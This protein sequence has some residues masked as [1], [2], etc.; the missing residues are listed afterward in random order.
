MITA[1][2]I[3]VADYVTKYSDL[4]VW[5]SIRKNYG[6][7][8]Y[9]AF[10]CLAAHELDA[11][12]D[13]EQIVELIKKH[14]IEDGD[15]IDFV[16]GIADAPVF[17]AEILDIIR[18]YN[19]MDVIGIY[20]EYLAEDF[21]M[22]NQAV[23]F[24]C[25]KNNRDLL[26]S[27]YTR[28]DFAYQITKKA[29][30][31]YYL[32]NAS[33]TELLRVAD[34]SCGGGAFLLS[35]ARFCREKNIPICLYGYDVDPI[36]VLITRLRLAKEMGVEIAAHIQL[37]N[38]LL[39]E[40]KS[41]GGINLFKKAISGR[42]YHSDMGISVEQNID[43]VIGNPPWEKIRFEEKKFLHHYIADEEISTK[44]GREL[45]LHQTLKENQLYYDNMVSD[46]QQTKKKIKSNPLFSLTNCG[47]LNTYALFTELSFNLLSDHGVV[48]LIIKSSLVKMP[49]YRKFFK[50]ITQY[51]N[52]YELYMFVNR[53]KLFNID[54]R[55]EFSV[56][57][58]KKENKSNLKLA[59][60]LDDY[61]DFADNDKIEL[62]YDLLNLLNPDTGMVPNI[63]NNTELNFLVRIYRKNKTFGEVY[64]TCKFGRLVHLT[65]H[66]ASI[67]NQQEENYEQIYEGKFIEMYTGNYATFKNMSE[68]DK[69][70][71]KASAHLI[72][73]INGTEYPEARYFINQDIWKN[74][75]KNFDGDYM[76]AWRSLTSATNRRTM[77]ATILPLIPTCQSIQLLQ[78]TEPNEMI[79]ILF[80]FNSIVFDYIIRLKMAGLDLTQTIIKQIPIPCKEA[81]SGM[82]DFQGKLASI[83]V[84]VYSRIYKLYQNDIRLFSVFKTINTYDVDKP[85]KEIMAELDK[86]AAILYDIDEKELHLIAQSF[87]KYYSKEEVEK[88]F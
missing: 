87:D 21:I 68:V 37:G 70:K 83:E 43:I 84:H 23:A 53:K 79:H 75:S 81:F 19:G 46:Y 76:V 13:A 85:R 17:A 25:G 44:S 40:Q 41:L 16:M 82:L 67:K 61:M 35:A 7:Y 4:T 51:K 2:R 5:E 18:L 22:I 24:E 45:Q 42:I 3:K 48:S 50:Q 38:P 66:S 26:G 65:T 59:L 34:L 33:K 11:D 14:K 8:T 6:Y 54:S 12:C 10:L 49:V 55:E 64:P 36:A 71:N 31:D 32:K 62:S 29:I 15:V 86:L 9:I 39:Q 60:D 47:E 74:I 30:N 72:A 56:L 52:L 1:L 73:D 88:W 69:Y 78:L 28:E 58:M 20:Q 63:K 57:Y 27:Y 80:L 77:L